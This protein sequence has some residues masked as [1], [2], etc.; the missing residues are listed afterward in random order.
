MIYS[1]NL[2][3]GYI[4]QNKWY[5]DGNINASG[6]GTTWEKAFKTIQE[7]INGA[8]AGDVV[9]IAALGYDTDASD[10]KQYEENLTIAYAK[11][12]LKLIG[13]NSSGTRLPYCGPK[14]KNASAAALLH[15]L[16]P[17]V[18]LEN[19][20]FNCTRNSGTYGIRL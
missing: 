12:D 19:L 9:Y 7:G 11:H 13:V 14:I 4:K 5:V 18:H 10:P 3:G 6:D 17:G 16:A 8:S 2:S 15:V 20:Q 1:Q